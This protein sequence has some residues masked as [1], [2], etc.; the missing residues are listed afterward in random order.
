MES[1]SISE[2][3]SSSS[4][5][6]SSNEFELN[7][8][9]VFFDANVSRNSCSMSEQLLSTIANMESQYHVSAETRKTYLSTLKRAS[10]GGKPVF[11][12]NT[13]YHVSLDIPQYNNYGRRSTV[14]TR[15]HV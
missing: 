7:N 8:R 4:S 5:S 6:K 13:P 3:S 2:N 14:V 11:V 9:R 10:S 12:E 1:V 15:D